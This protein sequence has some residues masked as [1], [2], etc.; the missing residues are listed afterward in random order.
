MCKVE[1]HDSKNIFIVRL[2]ISHIH[3][4]S[5]LY[6]ILKTLSFCSFLQPNFFILKDLTILVN[7][8]KN[9]NSHNQFWRS[10]VK[11]LK[12][13]HMPNQ[14]YDNTLVFLTFYIVLVR[15]SLSV[16]RECREKEVEKEWK[17][18]RGKERQTYIHELIVI[19]SLWIIYFLT[20]IVSKKWYS[21]K[22]NYYIWERFP[23]PHMKINFT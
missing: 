18:D 11:K 7:K 20:A 23:R 22:Y 17:R 10:S 21:I 6:E 13:F 8:Q 3:N 4:T 15:T 9:S 2:C 1:K 14:I 16:E 12:I 5:F 19:K